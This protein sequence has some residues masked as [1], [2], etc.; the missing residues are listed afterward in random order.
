MWKYLIKAG[1]RASRFLFRGLKGGGR[2]IGAAFGKGVSGRTGSVLRTLWRTVD[3]GLTSYLIY[4]TFWGED[5]S[6]SA[7][8]DMIF[9][10]LISP[11]V[12]KQLALQPQDANVMANAFALAGMRMTETEIGKATIVGMG[13]MACGQYIRQSP[14]GTIYSPSE[15]EEV[16]TGE[17]LAFLNSDGSMS[18]DE[19]SEVRT[20]MEELNFDEM[21]LGQLR[22]FDFICFVCSE[23]QQSADSVEGDVNGGN[24]SPE[25]TFVPPVLQN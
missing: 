15:I 10:G 6:S 3:V 9:D 12:A 25:G 2:L 18:E 8:Y 21:D 14:Y 16:L 13:L 23:L 5:G 4:D 22:Q 20:A 24:V 17:T 1:G 19:L 11:P 7:A